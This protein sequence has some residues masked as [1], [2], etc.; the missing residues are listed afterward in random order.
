MRA[1]QD[2]LLQPP[3]PDRERWSVRGE[4]LPRVPEQRSRHSRFGFQQGQPPDVPRRELPLRIRIVAVEDAV[5]RDQEGFRDAR[6][7][8]LLP[9]NPVH[10]AAILSIPEVA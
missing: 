8:P 6:A 9:E 4:T 3:A 7:V 1:A 2:Q 10:A 5:T